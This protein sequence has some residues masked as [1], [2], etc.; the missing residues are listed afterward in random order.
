MQEWD[1]YER[2]SDDPTDTGA[3]V[4]R[5]HDDTE[6]AVAARGGKVV[7]HHRE[8]DTSAYKTRRVT[9]TNH[10]GNTYDAWRA[11]RPV[12]AAALQRLRSGEAKRL[13]VY[14]LDR[15]AR[16]PR[17]LEDA[18]E[19]VEHYG[20]DIRS[21]TA[22]EIDLSTLP[23]RMNARLLV[24]M[25]NKASADTARRV[26]RQKLDRATQSIPHKGRHRL[27]GYDDEWN[28]IEEEA[29]IIKESFVRRALGES[30]TSICKDFNRRGIKTVSGNDW[31]SGTLGVTLTKH[32]YAGK[33][34]Y[35]GEVVADCIYPAIVDIATF[36]AAQSELA[37]DSRGTN[38]RKYLLS[39]ILICRHC[40]TQMKGN[41]LASSR[42][43]MR[44]VHIGTDQH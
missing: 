41:A 16:D 37:N 4:G 14:D 9:I 19:V 7:M 22:S 35:K 12:W 34:T 38:A 31:R 26:S 11:I 21:A 13:M 17:D 2:I 1:A 42:N 30:V 36:H 3:G 23:G 33:V 25:A 44:R 6:V 32:V 43:F 5:Q 29:S 27:Y 10:Y 28:V 39:G 8:N 18:I 40:P 20:A 15:L 24:M